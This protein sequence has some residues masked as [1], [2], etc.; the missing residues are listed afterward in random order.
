MAAHHFGWLLLPY[1]APWYCL[2]GYFL[3]T[4][5]GLGFPIN[6]ILGCGYGN[7]IACG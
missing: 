4:S 5:L 1:I 2:S 7:K 6:F 3:Q